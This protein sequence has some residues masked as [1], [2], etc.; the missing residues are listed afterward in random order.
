MTATKKTGSKK[1][2]SKKWIIA[3]LVAAALCAAVFLIV[4]T[5]LKEDKGDSVVYV[6]PVSRLTDKFL[7]GQNIYAGIVVTQGEVTV[8]N[9][10]GNRISDYYV[11]E[12]DTVTVGTP[13]FK[14]DV[15]A[16]Q[17]SLT[18][19]EIARD[20][21][22][23]ALES[24]QKAR[25]DAQ[26][27][28]NE[29][30]SGTRAAAELSLRDA[31]LGL[32]EAKLTFEKAEKAVNEASARIDNATVL[33]E[34]DGTVSK[35]TKADYGNQSS[36]DSESS[37]M[38]GAV[39][40]IEKSGNL[41]VK[42]TLSELDFNSIEDGME[43]TIQSRTDESKVWTGTI[44]KAALTESAENKE[45]TESQQTNLAYVTVDNS[46]DMV[47]GQHVKVTKKTDGNED[48]RIFIDPSYIVDAEKSNPYV[49]AD[50]G[51]GLLEKRKVQL[52][53]K[54][55]EG[56]YEILSGIGLTDAIVL[57]SDDL[58]VGMT[59]RIGE[60]PAEGSSTSAAEKEDAGNGQK[61]DK[62]NEQKEDK[63]NE[64]KDTAGNGQKETGESSTSAV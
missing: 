20:R 36:T 52:G 32:E 34:I 64:Q 30:D 17:D 47:S 54:D 15:N 33:S 44:K 53:G 14:Y 31:E 41:Q 28:L 58:A 60:P 42:L 49:W 12:G 46:D 16:L 21:A 4:K 37:A 3:A 38:G 63:G 1:T 2:G 24:A 19:K 7:L 39:I 45:S 57:P 5:F 55:D 6:T 50:D 27:A 11:K 35:V 51:T 26:K 8:N 62:G 59:C 43:V 56:K 40:T 61:E 29:A 18:S 13:L 22:K 10:D 25:D 9:E 48:K 23:I